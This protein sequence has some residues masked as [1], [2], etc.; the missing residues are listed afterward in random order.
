MANIFPE[1][2]PYGRDGVI[3]FEGRLQGPQSGQ[4]YSVVIE[5]PITNYPEMEPAVY[6]HPRPEGNYWRMD[7]K[8][9]G[10]LCV[11]RI[12]NPTKSTF[13]N[14]LLVAA[15]YIDHFDDEE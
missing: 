7:G 12:W 14:T 5:A 6:I 15:K 2:R 10:K 1:F 4:L 3:G 13:A 11:K 8:G 9:G